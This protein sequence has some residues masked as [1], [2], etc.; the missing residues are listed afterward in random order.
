MK[1]LFFI[2]STLIIIFG[3]IYLGIG[4]YLAQ[5]ILKNDHSC[6]AHEGSFPNTWSTKKDYQDYKNIERAALRKN[7]DES[8]YYLDQW[9]DVYFPSRDGKIKINGWLF[10]YF[11]NKPIIIVVHGILRINCLAYSLLTVG[12]LYFR[13]CSI[14]VGTYLDR[15]SY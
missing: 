15:S 3:I 14:V 10:N 4:F 9:E 8:L 1:K 13:T 7:F 6:G 11:Y 5:T 2:V 12:C